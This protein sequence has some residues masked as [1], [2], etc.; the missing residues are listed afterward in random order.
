MLRM[1]PL[2]LLLLLTGCTTPG[3]G[4][5][6]PPS[7]LEV[8][9]LSMTAMSIAINVEK[10]NEDDLQAIQ[11]ALIMTKDGVLLALDTDPGNVAGSI[12]SAIKGLD[13]LYQDLI[14]DVM[15][16]ALLRIRPYI[17]TE[18]QDIQL[19]K[20]YFQ[21]SIDGALAAINRARTRA[22]SG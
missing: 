17:D 7:P 9:I 6:P 11:A 13:P 4:T 10:M 21:A 22:D 2:I 18:N 16:L 20:D 19:A 12:G 1:L 15:Q 14:S 8:K 3:S 5:Q